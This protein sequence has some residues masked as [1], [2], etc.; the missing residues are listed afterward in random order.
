M[1]RGYN[2]NTNEKQIKFRRFYFL[3]PLSHTNINNLLHHNY[4]CFL[5]DNFDF[6]SAF[7]DSEIK[8]ES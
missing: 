6:L 2:P 7:L 3:F 4:F 1:G 8:M 5:L